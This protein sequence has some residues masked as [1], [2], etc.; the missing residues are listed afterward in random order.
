MESGGK[1]QEDGRS[2]FKPEALTVRN[3]DNLLRI[4]TLGAPL[5]KIEF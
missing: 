1:R 3:R 4:N 5:V 2:S